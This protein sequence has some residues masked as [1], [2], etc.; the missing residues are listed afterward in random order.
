MQGSIKICY[1]GILVSL[2]AASTLFCRVELG[3]GQIVSKGLLCKKTII[4]SRIE[5]VRYQP[6][7]TFTQL[8]VRTDTDSVMFSS[9]S[10][11]ARQLNA[12]R[13]YCDQSRQAS[14]ES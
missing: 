12:I 1:L 8:V 5:S 2:A 14:Q 4:A 9:L 7:A 3:N 13:N 10:F 6:A 11:S